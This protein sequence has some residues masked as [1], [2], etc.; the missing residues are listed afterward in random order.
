LKEVQ[1]P[2]FKALVD[3]SFKTSGLLK[4]DDESFTYRNLNSNEVTSE[5]QNIDWSKFKL[6]LVGYD[7]TDEYDGTGI[8]IPIKPKVGSVSLEFLSDQSGLNI[9]IND[10]LKVPLRA[11]VK[12]HF[13]SLGNNFKLSVIG[14]SYLS[15]GWTDGFKSLIDGLN[16]EERTTSNIH[17]ENYEFL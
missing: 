7:T 15:G 6:D 16:D 14:V 4:H 8:A 13:T 1:L 5:I 12:Q 11:G 3:V 9:S 17:I 2:K 10:T